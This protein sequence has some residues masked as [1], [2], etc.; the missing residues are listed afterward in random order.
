MKILHCI[1]SLSGG[2]AET[3]LK[4]LVE[5]V[6]PLG[7]EI[8]IFCIDDVGNDIKNKKIKI[9]KISKKKYYPKRTFFEIKEVINNWQPDIVHSWLPP[10]ITMPTMLAAKILKKPCITSY[11]NRLR[12]DSLLRIPDFLL[13]LFCSRK[14]ISNNVVE[15]SSLQYR[16]LFSLKK[17]VV[18]PNAVNVSEEFVLPYE[19]RSIDKGFRFLFV[20]RLTRQKNWQ[21]LVKA[22]SLLTKNLTWELLICGHGEDRLA[23]EK[24]VKEFNIQEKVKFVGYRTDVYKLMKEAHIL[25]LP[26]LYEG[27]PNVVLEAMATGLPCVLSDIPAHR[28]LLGDTP[29]AILVKVKDSSAYAKVF[30]DALEGRLELEK[31][32]KKGI[33]L[34]ARYKPEMVAKKYLA[35]YRN[36]L[37]K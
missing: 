23:A 4:R 24:L 29:A 14:I 36:L 20:G 25:V 18:I 8:A 1:H 12:F 32:S 17:G 15:Y 30:N 21:T 27:M 9:F 33:A 3:Q 34:A 22:V 28:G 10:S 13:Q 2:G 26:S 37:G 7:C 6:E 5:V 31:L 16:W 19:H 35:L 11:R